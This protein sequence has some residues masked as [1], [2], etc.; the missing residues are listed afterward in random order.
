MRRVEFGHTVKLREHPK[1]C[2]YQAR[3]ETV[4]WPGPT[5]Q[6]TVKKLEDAPMGNPQPSPSTGTAP[7]GCC[8]QTKCQWVFLRLRSITSRE[9]LRYSRALAKA[10]CGG[11]VIRVRFIGAYHESR[12]RTSHA[13]QR[14]HVVGSFDV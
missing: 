5:T 12:H 7:D 6:G 9:G 3:L 2:S 11:G 13:P 10:S 1:A 4:W 14:T 8:S